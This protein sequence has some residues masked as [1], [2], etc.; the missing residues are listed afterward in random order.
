MAGEIDS[1]RLLD[2][3]HLLG[4][5]GRT[6]QGALARLAGSDADK[7]GRDQ[8]VAWMHEAGLEVAVDAIGNIHGLWR[9]DPDMVANPVLS[10][11]HIDSV[12]NAG[13]YDGCLGV[14]A[15]LE[16]VQT[17]KESG[18][19]PRRPLGVVA[20]TN[21]EGVRFQPDMLG[22]LVA[23]GGMPLETARALKATDG[24]TLGA[25]LDRI[26]YTGPHAPG[27]LRPQAFVELHIEQGPVLEAE[28]L[29]LGVVDTL[30]GISWQ[31]ITI[32]GTANHAGTTPMPL[33]HDAGAVAARVITFLNDFARAGKVAVATVGTIAFA[34]NA[35]NVIPA[36]A[37]FTV[38][39][40]DPD[41]TRLVE[42][43]RALAHRVAALGKVE[44][45][46]V[47]SQR[48]ARFQPVVFDAG[49]VA[50]IEASARA[51]GLAWRR[52]TSGAGQDAQMM[53]RVC[54]TAMI[55]VPS[56]DGISHNPA[57]FTAPADIVAGAQVLLD[58]MRG[59]GE[60]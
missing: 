9:P 16:V 17:L 47:A 8:L 46:R 43:E 26:G 38:D 1:G 31:R 57:E 41:E 36:R 15:A 39:L 19:V 49:I 52:M 33:R 53:A 37:S 14:L 42:A 40:R 25:E 4:Q 12:I 54:P 7:A 27:F 6:A 50:R 21:E 32:E 10:G 28:N 18:Y 58:V 35:I 13:I 44:G 22:S 23:A 51:R 45:V 34:P 20:F 5:I 60:G 2:R 55:F 3:I 59:L 48:L 30:Q 24:P 56:H 11:S 29:R